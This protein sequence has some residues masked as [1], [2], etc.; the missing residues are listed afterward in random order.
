[1]TDQAQSPHEGEEPT[2]T[3]GPQGMDRYREQWLSAHEDE[4]GEEQETPP[5]YA[6]DEAETLQSGE[7]REPAPEEDARMRAVFRQLDDNDMLGDPP[8]D[9]EEMR[10]RL[11][12]ALSP[13]HFMIGSDLPRPAVTY[14]WRTRLPGLDEMLSRHEED[15][16]DPGLSRGSHLALHLSA[17]HGH[18]DAFL[19]TAGQNE[20]EHRAILPHR[21][22]GVQHRYERALAEKIEADLADL[23][24]GAATGWRPV[25]HPPHEV[26]DLA[27]MI[28]DISHQNPAVKA[29]LIA[30]DLAWIKTA[31]WPWRR[32]LLAALLIAFPLSRPPSWHLGKRARKAVR[33]TPGVPAQ[34]R[35]VP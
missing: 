8:F 20:A 32:R 34:E 30:V 16:E 3:D 29:D 25:P 27:R 18:Q 6:P 23:A 9:L 35:S 33:K 22:A 7:D 19:R 26:A 24:Y 28:G 17:A 2:V 14:G 13:G 11:D 31:G 21:H 10:R 1:M 5:G 15:A 4:T 12:E